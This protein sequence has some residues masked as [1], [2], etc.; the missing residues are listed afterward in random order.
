MA[1]PQGKQIDYGFLSDASQRLQRF[2]G[3]SGELSPKVEAEPKLQPVLLAGDLTLPGYGSTG[4][5]RWAASR[6]FSAGGANMCY[7]GYKASIDLIVTSFD[8][9][10]TVGA[11]LRVAYL[12]PNDADPFA[13]GTATGVFID[14]AQ[15]VNETSPVVNGTSNAAL[16]VLSGTIKTIK[17]NNAA[18]GVP[19]IYSDPFFMLAGSKLILYD[20]SAVNNTLA[21][22]VQGRAP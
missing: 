15:S 4:G 19:I 9:W 5:R 20:A 7:V 6:D 18:L 16:G 17:A 22:N 8:I 11:T 12:G 21:F 14:R 10:Y 3:V 13:F 1:A 2:L